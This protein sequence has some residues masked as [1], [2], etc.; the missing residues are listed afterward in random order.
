MSSSCD[1]AVWGQ[2]GWPRTSVRP[3]PI[4][5]LWS[6]SC[7][8]QMASGHLADGQLAA[9]SCWLLSRAGCWVVLA[10]FGVSVSRSLVFERSALLQQC[11][12]FVSDDGHYFQLSLMLQRHT[13]KTS[14]RQPLIIQICRSKGLVSYTSLY[15]SDL[16][17]VLSFSVSMSLLCTCGLKWPDVTRP[18]WD[19]MLVWTDGS[20]LLL[21]R[22]I[23]L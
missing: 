19:I 21:L 7:C 6:L 12:Q 14:S 13:D 10:V 3:P 15:S 18:W 9:E 11:S 17:L 2:M 5:L 22:T 1:V 4:V 16:P 8:G 23:L 20:L